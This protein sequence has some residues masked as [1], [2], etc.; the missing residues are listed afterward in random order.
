MG[1]EPKRRLVRPV[2]VV[3][4]QHRRPPLPEPHHQPVQCMQDPEP[5]VAAHRTRDTY[6]VAD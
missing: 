5:A 2:R 3:D 1:E 4:H 6:R